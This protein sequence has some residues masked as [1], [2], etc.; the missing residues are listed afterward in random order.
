MNVRNITVI[1]FVVGIFSIN[2]SLAKTDSKQTK[3]KSIE[4]YMKNS[5]KKKQSDSPQENKLTDKLR[6]SKEQQKENAYLKRMKEEEYKMYRE[7]AVVRYQEDKDKTYHDILKKQAK[8]VQ[9]ITR[10]REMERIHFNSY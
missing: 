5:L 9:E 7:D 2:A 6:L 4:N 10:A 3:D 8:E 1:L